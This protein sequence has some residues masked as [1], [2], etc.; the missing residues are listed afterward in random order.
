MVTRF[1][2]LESFVAVHNVPAV[3]RVLLLRGLAVCIP[4]EGLLE[5]HITDPSLFPT[6]GVQ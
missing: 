5:G 1:A 3:Y 6:Q 2:H 4:D